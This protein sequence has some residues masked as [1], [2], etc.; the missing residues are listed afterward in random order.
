MNDTILASAIAEA[1]HKHPF[2]GYFAET[3]SGGTYHVVAVVE[4]QIIVEGQRGH[5]LARLI[6]TG[7]APHADGLI[8]VRIEFADDLGDAEGTLSFANGELHVGGYAN[9]RLFEAPG[10]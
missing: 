2:H 3:D 4:G 7:R 9:Y 6:K 1:K 8:R 10:A 5:A